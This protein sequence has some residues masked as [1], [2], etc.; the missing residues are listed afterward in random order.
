MSTKQDPYSVLGVSK[1]ATDDE[2]KKAYRSKARKSHPDVDKTQG[3]EE[4][5][6]EV[7]EAYQIL[8]DSNKRTAYDQYGHSAFDQSAGFGGA[9]PGGGGAGGPGGF[10]YQW[11][12]QDGQGFGGFEDA[13][14]IFDM[15]FGG[16]SPFGSRNR[17][18]Q[19]G[20]QLTFDEAV[21][22]VTK[23]FEI[24]NKRQKVKIPAGVDDGTSIRFKDFTIICQ[25]SRSSK[26][27]RRGHDIYT[28]AKIDFTQAAL[29]GVVEV[30]TIDGTVKV[31]IPA[32]TQPDT[33]IRLAGK[34]VTKI[35]TKS[36]GDHYIIITITIPKNLNSKQKDLLKE[37]QE[38]LGKK[39]W[40]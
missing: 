33:K 1:N 7:N 19:Y 23:E 20:L 17:T 34:G 31:K 25:V 30:E 38:S 11:S 28:E 18:P 2:I 3:A 14:D 9:R 39:G 8:S 37:L 13:F 16:Q 36:R 24:N 12:S 29:G 32:G 35:N 5:F 4:R 40:F 22:G 6:K 26:F 15:M 10:S 21:H 27:V